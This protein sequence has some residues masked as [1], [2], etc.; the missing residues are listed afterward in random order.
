MTAREPAQ[1]L[2]ELLPCP[3]CGLQVKMADARSAVIDH[4]LNGC[5][6]EGL[7]AMPEDWNTRAAPPAESAEAIIVAAAENLMAVKGRH[8]TE[9]AYERLRAAIA[10]R[11]H[12]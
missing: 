12:G 7:V 9:V 5:W 8:N 2:T 3:F 10:G 1:A 11:K 4:A 6:L